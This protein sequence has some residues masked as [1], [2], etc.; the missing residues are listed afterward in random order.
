MS[1]VQLSDMPIELLL[2]NLLPVMPVPDLLSLTSTN[3]YFSSICNDDTFWKRK[4]QADFNFSGAGTARTSGWKFIYKGLSQPQVYVWGEAN[5]GRLGIQVRDLPP[6]YLQTAGV[7]FP[8]RLRIPGVRIVALIA[9]G[10]SFHALDSEGN[11]FVWGTLDGTTGALNSDGFSEAGKVADTPHRL[12]MPAATRTISCGRLHSAS[13]DA[14]YQI[15]NFLNWGR[16]FEL[17][18]PAFLDPH[19]EPIQVE[20]GW[21]FTSC[22][23]ATGEVYVWW[24][25][26]EGVSEL[27]R[28]RNRTM[29]DEHDKKAQANDKKD[30]PC[31]PWTLE[32]DPLRLGPLPEL[33]E[34]TDAAIRP[35]QLEVKII[36]IAGMDNR[37]IAVTNYGHVLIHDSL[38]S[39]LAAIRGS[40]R[41][42]PQF[43][44][45]KKLQEQ[46]AFT[47]GKVPPPERLTVTHVS[48]HY[49]HFIAYSTEENSYVLIGDDATTPESVPKVIPELQNISVIS[50]VLGDYHSGALTSTGKLYTWGSFSKGALGLG[51]PVQLRP[52]TPGGF[53]DENQRL[54]AE[55]RGRPYP[56]A[57]QVPTEVR[58]DHDEQ[59]QKHKFCF[60]AAASGWHSAAL[61][62]D[63]EPSG[64][65]GIDIQNSASGS[66]QGPS[67]S[68]SGPSRLP[69][70]PG[71][72]LPQEPGYFRFGFAARG[73]GAPSQQGGSRQAWL[74]GRGL[75][76]SSDDDN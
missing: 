65:E 9:G 26:S 54:Q 25:Y 68:T 61:V 35:T 75:G 3:K 53:V 5:H 37:L 18:T 6:S 44:E 67:S 12:V 58:F 49:E 27:I 23:T 13:L 57:V 16:P 1:A 72:H 51:D 2:D 28:A 74:R 66:S 40:W 38:E 71:L 42:L 56:P 76:F 73:T 62:I 14:N 24:P 70:D 8:T 15:W 11:I 59:K 36:Q 30:I 48:A 17:S 19:F 33:P 4:L 39:E 69:G 32:N 31:V 10:M 47:T 41:Y 50:V 45:A 7:P 60:S 22:L 64:D 52:G 46:E 63:L 43:S 55:R 21:A 20:C 29:D 34:L